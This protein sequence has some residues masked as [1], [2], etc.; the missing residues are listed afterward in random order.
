M[1]FR[2]LNIF[3]ASIFFHVSNVEADCA[4]NIADPVLGVV[5]DA[6]T[7]RFDDPPE[8]VTKFFIEEEISFEKLWVITKYKKNDGTY[9]LI[10]RTVIGEAGMEVP[11]HGE[12]IYESKNGVELVC[13]SAICL[14]SDTPVP[15]DVVDGLYK[16]VADRYKEVFGIEKIEKSIGA[17]P[18]HSIAYRLANQLIKVGVKIPDKKICD[19][20]G[21]K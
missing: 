18:D 9:Y 7:I 14:E 20:S 10:N 17:Y 11:A 15:A 4:F 3:I 5:Y 16:N 12:V 6:N 1:N 13:N 2:F 21:C 8:G 19:R